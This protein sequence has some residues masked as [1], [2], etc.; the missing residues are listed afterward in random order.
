MITAT[1][2][3]NL[4]TTIASLKKLDFSERLSVLKNLTSISEQ[5]KQ[6]ISKA[7]TK[8]RKNEP[9]EEFWF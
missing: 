7:F 5:E 1:W 9:K 3:P 8:F 4:S 6:A 2:S